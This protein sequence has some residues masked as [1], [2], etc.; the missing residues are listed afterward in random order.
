M[1]IIDTGIFILE[2][3]FQRDHRYSIN[4]QF[5]LTIKATGGGS[6]FTQLWNS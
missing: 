1:V 3:R 2:F 4:N 6:L 5:L